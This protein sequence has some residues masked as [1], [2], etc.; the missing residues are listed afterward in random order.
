MPLLVSVVPFIRNTL[1]PKF[2]V[3]P[4]LMVILRVTLLKT[5]GARNV[6][7]WLAEVLLDYQIRENAG[8]TERLRCASK[9]HHPT[10]PCRPLLYWSR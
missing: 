9:R 7:V 6:A 5:A 3:V 8:D 10:A 4:V 1:L 2:S